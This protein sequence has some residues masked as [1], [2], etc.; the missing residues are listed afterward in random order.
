MLFF[1][2]LTFSQSVGMY[3]AYQ[4]YVIEGRKRMKRKKDCLT[5]TVPPQMSLTLSLASV[6]PPPSI[7]E[8]EIETTC[9]FDLSISNDDFITS[10]HSQDRNR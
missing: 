2:K 4:H 9:N 6:S 1:D 7:S 10:P 3:C 5:P 8:I